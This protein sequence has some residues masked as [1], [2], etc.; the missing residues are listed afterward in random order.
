MDAHSQWLGKGN[1]QLFQRANVD[2]KSQGY[3]HSTYVCIYRVIFPSKENAV[4]YHEQR[5]AESATFD[6]S[7]YRN[8]CI[9][10]V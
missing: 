4:W 5:G 8:K 2:R 10:V 7:S 1:K 9:V 3:L 6:T